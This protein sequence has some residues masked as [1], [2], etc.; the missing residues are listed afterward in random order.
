MSA[1]SPLSRQSEISPTQAGR[2][3][4]HGLSCVPLS[5]LQFCPL[6]TKYLDSHSLSSQPVCLSERCEIYGSLC[7]RCR[8]CSRWPRQHKAKSFRA[9]QASKLLRLPIACSF[10]SLARRSALLGCIVALGQATIVIIVAHPP[11]RSLDRS[12]KPDSPRDFACLS[13]CGGANLRL[14]SS[15]LAARNLQLEAQSFA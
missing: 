12:A 4:S 5:W 3:K 8:V 10:T 6:T 7:E 11:N 14:C 9:W 15:Q 1:G 2:R 13:V